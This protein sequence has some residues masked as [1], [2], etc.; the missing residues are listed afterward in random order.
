MKGNSN[1]TGQTEQSREKMRLANLGKPKTEEAKR[2]MSE[3]AKN[4]AKVKCQHCSKE[5][6][7][8]NFSR[9]HGDKCKMKTN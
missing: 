5:V 7:P 8:S 4:R 2:K 9:W 6:S 1:W 3:A